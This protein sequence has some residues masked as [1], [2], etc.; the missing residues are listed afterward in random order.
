MLFSGASVVGVLTASFLSTLH[1]PMQKDTSRNTI[2][3]ADSEIRRMNNFRGQQH[4]LAHGM[5]SANKLLCCAQYLQSAVGS[6]MHL[7]DDVFACNDPPL[8]LEVVLFGWC[9]ST[10]LTQ[11]LQAILPDATHGGGSSRG[12]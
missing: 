3:K 10:I 6:Q 4:S 8:L 2:S 9:A 5:S 1:V 12:H 7:L 11:P